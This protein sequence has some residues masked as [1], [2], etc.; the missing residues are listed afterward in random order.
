[1]FAN[2]S[3]NTGVA[4]VELRMTC[5]TCV[6][7]PVNA[8]EQYIA[9]PTPAVSASPVLQFDM[10]GTPYLPDGNYTAR[11][12]AQDVDGNR[13]I[14]EI[15]LR[16]DRSKHALGLYPITF[17]KGQDN[18]SARLSPGSGAY[19]I[20]GLTQTDSYR[21]G[22][23]VVDP[24]GG[25]AVGQSVFSG[26]TTETFGASFNV[27]GS[28]YFYSQVQNLNPLNPLVVPTTRVVQIVNKLP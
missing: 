19:S 24:K 27:D 9:Y 5:D 12:V 7:G 23:V 4:S 21:V 11:V 10:D 25:V 3:D 8:L 20:G 15:K 28:W 14:Q 16:L 2:I 6:G 17:A 1:M 13:N 22:E 26:Q 18:T